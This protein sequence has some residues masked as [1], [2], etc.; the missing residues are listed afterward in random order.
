MDVRGSVRLAYRP[1]RDIGDRRKLTG[2]NRDYLGVVWAF[3]P[4]RQAVDLA[5]ERF[6]AAHTW[7]VA[8]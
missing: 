4:N 2:T 7:R 6:L 3:G 5:V 1:M 8:A